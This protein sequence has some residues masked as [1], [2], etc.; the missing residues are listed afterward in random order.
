[1]RVFG[2]ILWHFPF[3]GFLIAIVTY[4]IGLLLTITII[5]APVGLGLMELGK[6]L[7]LPFGRNMV[8][9]E[10]IT[11]EQNKYWLM[12]S[13]IIMVGYVIFIGIWLFILIAVYVGV[14]FLTIIGIPFALAIAKH[15]GT[16][17]NPVNKK[18]VHYAVAAELERIEAQKQIDKMIP[19][20]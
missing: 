6:C 2:N 8:S 19:K 18:C 3:F 11:G 7:F 12:Y 13:K 20:K 5:A 1:M 10:K 4:L 16:Y 17:F 15:I 9:Q 14:L